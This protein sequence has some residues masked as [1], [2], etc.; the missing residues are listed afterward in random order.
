MGES[1]SILYESN[2][3]RFAERDGYNKCESTFR[4][5]ALRMAIS[6]T[7]P[8]CKAYINIGEESAGQTGQCPRCERLILIPSS[9]K[10]MPILL[11]EHGNPVPILTPTKAV[12]RE[13]A[14]PEPPRRARRVSVEKKPSGP[15]WPWL[16]GILGGIAVFVLLL[17]SFIVL[18]SYRPRENAS[19]VR[20]VLNNPAVKPV[21]MIG[22]LEGQRAF[23]QDGVFQMRASLRAD[24]ELHPQDFARRRK[25]YEIE[26]RGNT[27]YIFEMNSHVLTNAITMTDRNGNNIRDDRNPGQGNATIAFMPAFTDTYTVFVSSVHPGFGE[28]TLTIHEQG[29]MRPPVP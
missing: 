24:D 2:S 16:L 15:M 6:F 13:E 21:T 29:R 26:L 25:R 12:P 27:P 18:C 8:N 9:D 23:F 1:I 22:R 7:C 10:P 3:M 17:S 5:E 4:R 28:F 19:N 14:K 11:D 20:I